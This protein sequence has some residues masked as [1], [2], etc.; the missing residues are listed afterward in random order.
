VPSIL[1]LS[2]REIEQLGIAVADVIQDLEAA[3]AAKGRGEV[4]MPPKPGIHPRPDAFIHAMPAYVRSGDIAGLKWIAGYPENVGRGLPYIS[5]L[6]I[7][8]D[9]AT[10]IPLAVTD[11]TWITAVRTGA[12]TAVAAKH[13]AR[14]AASRLAIVGC[15]VQARSNLDALVVVQ[16]HLAE[17]LAYDIRPEAAAAFAE[18][19]ERHHHLRVTVCRTAEEAVTQG[20]IIV[21]ATPILK[22]PAPVVRAPWLAPGAFLC[23]LDFDSAVTP[24]AFEAADLLCTDDVAQ[25]DFYRLDGYFR[26]VPDRLVDL[27]DI[28]AGKSPGRAREDARIVSINLGLALEDVVTAHRIYR[29]AHAAG[30]GQTLEL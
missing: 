2:R 21:T 14:P 28:V 30:A 15:G 3:F 4:E 23:T 20:E 1:Y 12:A 16:P 11:A 13:L 17:V 19:G 5:G 22:H 29:A 10:G 7:L 27:G 9:P 26:G 8:N 25:L 6:M 18:Y 24:A